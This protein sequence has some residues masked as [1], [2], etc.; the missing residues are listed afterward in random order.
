MTEWHPMETAPRD[1]TMLDVRFDPGTAERDRMGSLA[2]FY[3]P[4]CT[5]RRD[6]TEPVILGVHFSNR[7]FRPGLPGDGFCACDL[8]VTLTG[9][10]PAIEDRA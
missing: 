1:G 3:A 6:P 9:W 2:E 5:R 4:G 8:S 7:H 10:R